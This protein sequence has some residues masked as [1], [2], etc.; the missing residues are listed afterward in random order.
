VSERR[1][2]VGGDVVR[3]RE[4]N[5]EVAPPARVPRRRRLAAEGN[6][7]DL[8]SEALCSVVSQT[9]RMTE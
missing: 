7:I 3:Q 1:R 8:T 6:V 9:R 2:A 4:R 5:S